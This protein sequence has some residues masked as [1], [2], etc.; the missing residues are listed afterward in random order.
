MQD[1][2][3]VA[4]LI[5]GPLRTFPSVWPQNHKI[6]GQLNLDLHFFLHTWDKNYDTHK[7]LMSGA[8]TKLF[9]KFWKPVEF[10][11][12]PPELIDKSKFNYANW[13]IQIENFDKFKSSIEEFLPRDQKSGN[14]KFYN[15]LSMYYGMQQV[16][17]M[18]LEGKNSFDFFLRI[19]PDFLLPNNFMI[20]KN[21][22]LKMYGEGV[23]IKG[24]LISDQCFSGSLPDS[25]EAMFAYKMLTQ[26]IV[27]E[28]WTNVKENLSRTGENVLF[29]HLTELNFLNRLVSK[30]FEKKGILIRQQS[31]VQVYDKKIFAFI[32]E[33][34]IYNRNIIY[35]RIIRFGADLKYFIKH[36]A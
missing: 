21:A 7:K 8:N 24:S 33:V 26:K 31:F 12:N 17:K 10:S 25:I 13:K 15:T 3:K 27:L 30:R 5:S 19:R 2:I 32:K 22:F 34:I 9:W 11:Q 1:P 20:D 18:L 6:L 16:A 35:K 36:R 29:E 28:G 23:S 4:I 14:E